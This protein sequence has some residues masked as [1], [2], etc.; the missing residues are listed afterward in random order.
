MKTKAVKIFV[1]VMLIAG[2][3]V[4]TACSDANDAN[5]ANALINTGAAAQGTENPAVTP[6]APQEL[7]PEELDK[8]WLTDRAGRFVG[9]P[10]EI[11]TIVTLGASN[12]EIVAALGFTDKIIGAD[13]FSEDVTGIT[14]DVTLIDMWNMDAE[15]VIALDADLVI[16]ASDLF[17][18]NTL[19][20]LAD[21]GTAV[22]F[23]PT[24]NTITGIYEDIQFLGLALNA[25]AEAEDIIR[26]M[27]EEIERIQTIAD[28][29]TISRSVYFEIETPPFM[30]TFG[31]GTFLDEMLQII[32][33]E[34]VFR[35]YG[36]WVSVSDEQVIAANPDVILTNVGW[37][38]DH[39]ADMQ[40]RPGW[41]GLDAVRGNNIFVIDANSSSRPTHNII[42]ALDQIARAV[43]P[44]YFGPPACRI[45]AG[46]RF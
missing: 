45:V 9:I 26:N 41:N 33:A 36:Q 5:E 43:Y 20:L 35:D 39:V 32:G 8:R 4:L 46:H 30:F 15:T 29:I 21:A 6:P 2:F 17:F 40:S 13:T 19:D 31:A 14:H 44:K 25:E 7:D 12:T 37:V 3:F 27:H 34:N 23:I 16:A 42:I 1:A 18:D 10:H 38:V 24:S 11:T 28:S 22:L